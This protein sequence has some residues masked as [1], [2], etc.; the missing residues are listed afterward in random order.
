MLWMVGIMT[1]QLLLEQPYLQRYRLGARLH[2]QVL[3]V[4]MT[5]SGRCR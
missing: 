3:G 4:F 2:Q 1:V 5:A